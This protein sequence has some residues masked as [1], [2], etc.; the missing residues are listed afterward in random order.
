MNSAFGATEAQN[1]FMPNF[2]LNQTFTVA[3]YIPEKVFCFVFFNGN[4]DLQWHC[5][6]T[7]SPE[8]PEQ[9]PACT[10]N[11]SSL[12]CTR[13][14]QQMCWDWCRNLLG[15]LSLLPETGWGRRS[16]QTTS[17]MMPA[18]SHMNPAL[19]QRQIHKLWFQHHLF[20]YRK[21]DVAIEHKWLCVFVCTCTGKKKNNNKTKAV[22]IPRE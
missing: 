14:R 10:A 3:P 20:S 6:T 17:S 5:N 4:A 11:I 8:Q 18:S 7:E 13:A 19:T 1:S 12:P 9:M 2:S 16:V 22:R 15:G 21:R